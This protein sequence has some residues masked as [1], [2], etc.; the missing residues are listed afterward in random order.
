[1]Y[2]VSTIKGNIYMFDCR[3]PLNYSAKTRAGN[4]IHKLWADGYNLAAAC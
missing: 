2:N 4:T 3:N 1:M